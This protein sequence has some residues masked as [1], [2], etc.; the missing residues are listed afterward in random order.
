[1]KKIKVYHNSYENFYRSPFGAVT[2]NR[3]ITL[4]IEVLGTEEIKNVY[5][6][7]MNSKEREEIFSMCI[8][9]E[10]EEKSIYEV[11]ITTP[12]FPCL[13][14]YYFIIETP[15]KTYY[16]GNNEEGL[17]GEGLLKEED[18][19]SYQIT[20]YKEGVSVPEWFKD[21]VIYQ[22]FPDRFYNER[23]E[24]EL[25]GV[26]ENSFIYSSWRDTPMYI[27]DNITQEIIRWDFF[28]GNLSGIIK[29]LSYLKELGISAIYLN[30]IFLSPSNHRYDIAD[31]KVIDPLLGD[32]ETFCFLCEEANKKGIAI[33]LDGVFS[34]TGSD[35]I[36]FNKEGNFPTLGA[37]QSQQSHYYPWYRFDEFP[38]KYDCWWGI[39][40]MPNVNEME[41]SYLDFIIEGE[42]SVLKHW[43]KM[44]TKGW[45]LDVADELP[46]AFIKRFKKT[47]KEVYPDSILIGEVWEDASNKY[48][49]GEKREYLFGEELD[50]VMN[51]PFRGAL[52]DFFIGKI[53]GEGLN[54]RLMSLYE[55]Y[56]REYFYSMMNLIGSHDVPRILTLL[57]ELHVEHHLTQRGREKLRLHKEQRNLAIKRLKLLALFQMT[58]PGVPTIYYGDEVGMEGLEDPLNRGTY[59]W[60]REDQDLLQW[61]K[62]M[63]SL[64]NKY[65]L[66]KGGEWFPLYT[67]GDI[68]SFVRKNQNKEAIIVFNRNSKEEYTVVLEVGNKIKSNKI[69]NILHNHEEIHI[70]ENTVEVSLKPLEGK[71]FLYD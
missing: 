9:E 60:G 67:Q 61:Y 50:S 31:Y 13:L 53:P 18:P 26:K 27:K 62:K 23:N 40:T 3:E 17:G 64:R 63:I 34:H 66:F 16:Y 38:N 43:I 28:G 20:I 44:G 59:P 10:I 6:K 45:R 15:C 1:M 21:A 37:Y 71:I 2:C 68:Y 54:K 70:Q 55:N 19:S 22:I 5:I 69:K 30:P 8:K 46:D 42:N 51:Y 48:S 12:L 65:D 32:N 41:I 14:H 52:L 11:K 25:L 33:I 29:K 36:Y 56:P 24:E 7:L 35:S 47:M 39:G 57:G 49:H 58:F 4:R